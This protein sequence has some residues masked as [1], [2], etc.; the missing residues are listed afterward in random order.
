MTRCLSGAPAPCSRVSRGARRSK[1]PHT[2]AALRE[3]S[4]GVAAG[5]LHVEGRAND[6]RLEGA[7]CSVLRDAAIGL[8][9]GGVGD[10]PSSD[11]VHLDTGCVRTW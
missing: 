9:R 1:P 7:D 10:Y 11:F 6:V 2:N 8:R 4:R 5:S 3:R